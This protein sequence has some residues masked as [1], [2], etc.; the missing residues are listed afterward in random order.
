MKA[1]SPDTPVV[2]KGLR[3]WF[4]VHFIVDMVVAIPLFVFPENVLTA[5][6]WPQIDILAIRLVA[7]AFFAIGIS[8]FLSRS[9]S[10]ETFHHLLNLKIIW[11]A[12]AVTGIAFT[13]LTEEL[14]RNALALVSSLVF[15][16]FLLVW[17]YWKITLKP[18]F[19]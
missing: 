19:Q 7:A 1:I 13:M 15:M 17:I 12:F 10:R 11:S 4:I 2:P 8:S 5:F 18:Y 14:Y 3:Q 16:I 9:G 6:A